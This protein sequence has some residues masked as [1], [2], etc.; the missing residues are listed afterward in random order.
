MELMEI[1]VPEHY[2]NKPASQ[3]KKQANLFTQQENEKALSPD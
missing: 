2:L 1:N 3:N